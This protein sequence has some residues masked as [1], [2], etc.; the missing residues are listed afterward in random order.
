MSTTRPVLNVSH[1]LKR[2]EMKMFV[3][4]LQRGELNSDSLLVQLEPGSC[5]VSQGAHPQSVL[6]AHWL[7]NSECQNELWEERAA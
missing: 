1:I 3:M 5:Q 6:E 7:A 2:T 4:S